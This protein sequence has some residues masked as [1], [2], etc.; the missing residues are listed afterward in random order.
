MDSHL[1]ERRLIA[2][3]FGLLVEISG[4][5]DNVPRK[6]VLVELSKHVEDEKFLQL[7]ERATQVVLGNEKYLGDDRKCFPTDQLGVAQGS[8][9]S[10]LLGNILLQ[11]FDLNFN[12]RGMVCVRFID[13]FVLLGETEAKVQKA[14][15]SAQAHLSKLGLRC[16]DPY[17]AETDAKKAERG[18]VSGGFDFLG[19]RIE[20][21][22]YQPSAK[23]RQKVLAEVDKHI[24]MGR[25]GITDCIRKADSFENR[26][27][28]AQTHDA[29]DRMLKGW[30]NAFAYTNSTST[31][32]D[33]DK[34]IDEK[35]ETFRKWFA[36][37]VRSLDRE[38][39][40]RAGGVCLLVDVKAKSLDELPFAMNGEK[41]RF[42]QSSRTITVSTDGSV[43]SSGKRSGRDKGPG[44]WAYVVHD[45]NQTVSGGCADVTNNQMELLAVL[46]A[47]RQLPQENSIKIPT[48]SRYVEQTFNKA[49]VVKSNLDMWKELRELASKRPIKITWVKGH[50]GDEQNVLADKL[51]KEAASQI[52]KLCRN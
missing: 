33:L 10:P 29:I 20:P 7:L 12:D 50:A 11:E 39:K 28:Y 8:P 31:M 26:Q 13:D 6:D 23:A 30:G 3:R 32:S 15:K 2:V 43:F 34:K 5:F 38:Q 45:T 47:L 22:L 42:R 1:S 44:G 51:A 35:L 14:F 49:M 46:Q 25:R 40:R 48:D 16:H 9:L 4:F 21:G 37:E 19:Y 52:K 24:R 41:K 27:R 17:A 36:N 18:P